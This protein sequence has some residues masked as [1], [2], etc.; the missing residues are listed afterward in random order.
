MWNTQ[1]HTRKLVEII[2][3]KF[4]RLWDSHK[5]GISTLCCHIQRRFSITDE[6]LPAHDKSPPVCGISVA[7]HVGARPDPTASAPSAT[8]WGP[9]WMSNWLTDGRISSDKKHQ[10]LI[11]E[12]H[13]STLGGWPVCQRVRVPGEGTF[14]GHVQ[15]SSSGGFS[16]MRICVVITKVMCWHTQLQKCIITPDWDKV[17]LAVV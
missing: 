5:L 13:L 1:R 2:C 6:P 9:A 4:N 7:V 8:T 16:S 10:W 15:L 11:T 3:K 12:A 17:H 14:S